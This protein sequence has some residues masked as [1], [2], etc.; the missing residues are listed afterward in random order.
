MKK[1]KFTEDCADERNKA[2]I[3][4]TITRINELSAKYGDLKYYYYLELSSTVKTPVLE[5]KMKMI[6]K[7]YPRETQEYSDHRLGFCLGYY[8]AC[9]LIHSY[10]QE[11]DSRTT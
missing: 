7:K 3:D 10:L 4:E 2:I 9:K 5:K 8:E 1:I 6:A 11:D